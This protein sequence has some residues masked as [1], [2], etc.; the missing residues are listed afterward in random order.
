M[1]FIT[2]DGRFIYRHKTIAEAKEEI[3][4]TNEACFK[5]EVKR[6]KQT[7][8][9]IGRP[10][11]LELLPDELINLTDPRLVVAD[12]TRLPEDIEAWTRFVKTNG[13]KS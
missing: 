10:M 5:E 1:A 11:K 4:E 6:F 2:E 9:V 13:G 12:G 7:T 3:N 8:D